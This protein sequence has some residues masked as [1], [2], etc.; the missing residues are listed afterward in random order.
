MKKSL[1]SLMIAFA[2]IAISGCGGG[3]NVSSDGMFGNIP[4]TIEKYDQEKKELNAGLNESNYQKKLAKIEDLKSETI[5]KLEKEGEGLNGKELTVSV[6]EAELKIETPL[7][8]VYKSVFSNVAAVEF[9]LNGKIEVVKELPLDV[10]VSDLTYDKDFFGKEKGCMVVKVPVH[11]EFLD[12]ENKVLNTCTLG[13]MIADNDGSKAV[14][15]QGTT[16]DQQG[17]GSVAVNARLGNAVSAR[18][19]LD[20]TNIL[21]SYPQ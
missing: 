18:V 8:W 17:A 20:M 2:A 12:K 11:L 7:T 19:I 10:K 5:A 1:F 16:M 6:D 4:Q 15:K 14:V 3:S 13:F 21:T 9:N